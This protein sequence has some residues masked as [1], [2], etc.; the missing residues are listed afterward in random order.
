[1]HLDTHTT[2]LSTDRHP[3]RLLLDAA[4][5]AARQVWWGVD[6]ASRLRHGMDVPADHGAR[7]EPRVMRSAHCPR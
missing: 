2:A 3:V 1:M 4:W 7:R 5:R 6:A